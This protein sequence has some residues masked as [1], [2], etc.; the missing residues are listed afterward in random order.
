MHPFIKRLFLFTQEF[1]NSLGFSFLFMLEKSRLNKVVSLFLC[2]KVS[3]F[4][5]IFCVVEGKPWAN[6]ELFLKQH[7][8][9]KKKII[10][11]AYLDTLWLIIH[12]KPKQRI[13][14]LDRLKIHGTS[15][16]RASK[17]FNSRKVSF[18]KFLLQFATKT[19]RLK[20]PICFFRLVNR[21]RFS[22][23]FSWS[24]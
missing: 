7:W 22:R 10:L 9:L 21:H 23:G 5:D 18:S 19:W 2:H 8:F 15:K 16:C 14:K 20:C 13:L 4:G 1:P 17:D 24:K 6:T 11:F 12:K 3:S